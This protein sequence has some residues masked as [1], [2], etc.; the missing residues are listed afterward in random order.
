MTLSAKPPTWLSVVEGQIVR[1]VAEKNSVL[2][3]EESMESNPGGSSRR[4]MQERRL[5]KAHPFTTGA[6]I[7][8]HI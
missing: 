4:H 2:L 1:A 5:Q 7:C 8:Q 3:P 6:P